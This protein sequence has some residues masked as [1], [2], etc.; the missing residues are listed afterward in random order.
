MKFYEFTNPYYALIKAENEN[1]AAKLYAKSVADI[2]EG[3]DV[4]EID[5]DMALIKCA[6]A[7]GEDN[8]YINSKEIYDDFIREEQEVLLIDYLL[9]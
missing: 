6:Q 9:I 5:C 4:K 7:L 1:N 8:D 2:D 3:V